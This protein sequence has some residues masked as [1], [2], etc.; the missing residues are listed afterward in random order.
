MNRFMQEKWSFFTGTFEMRVELL[1]SLSDSDLSFN[2]GG[3]NMTLGELCRESG[4]IDP[5]Y[6]QSL[7]TFK[8]DWAYRNTEAGLAT[9]VSQLKAWY[10]ALEKDLEVTLSALS[11]EDFKS[12]TIDRGFET[13]LD[14]Q[15]E[16][17]LQA[18]LIFLSKATIYLKAMNR[19]LNQKFQDWIG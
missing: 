19:P 3:L 14:F 18:L 4:E 8:Q 7:K 5:S 15:L 17:Y 11:D 6:I 16:I 2:P 12:K 9:S 10:Q 1:D 13:P